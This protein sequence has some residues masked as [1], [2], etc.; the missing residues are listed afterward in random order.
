MSDPIEQNGLEGLAGGPEGDVPMSFWD[1]FRELR[2]RLTRCV[3]AVVIGFGGSFAFADILGRYI[4][5][6]FESAWTAAKMPGEPTLQ[7]LGIQDP[8]MVDFRIALTA[9]IF[10]ALPVIFYQLW[11]FISPGLYSREKR[12]VVPFVVV[13]I[14]MFV[15]GA[16][17]AYAYVLPFGYAWL[18]DYGQG[19]GRTTI[20]PELG[21]YV[22]GT[23][24]VLLAFGA[25]F[26]FPLLIAFM[27]K[28]GLV[29]NRTLLRYWRIAVLAIFVVAAFLTP[30]EPITQLMMAGPMVLLFFASVLVAW[31]I[32]P[33][34][35]PEPEPPVGTDSR[36]ER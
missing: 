26:E 13:S 29:T 27:A 21:N 16:W 36:T 8:L 15:L 5:R 32:N 33:A 4:R 7:A 19:A 28:A 25:V 17:F 12:F 3:L 18:L 34:P 6:P 24:R 10:F 35:K 11:M 23:T 20:H 9:G 14:L 31:F 2:G 30:P 1:H 22:K